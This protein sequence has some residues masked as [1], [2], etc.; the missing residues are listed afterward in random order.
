[1][2]PP[3][4]HRSRSRIRLIL[5]AA[6]LV[7]A[8]AAI[9]PLD[10]AAASTPAAPAPA[11]T[12]PASTTPFG[13]NLVKN[14]NAESGLSGWDASLS[15]NF[16]AQTYGKPGRGYPSKATATAIGGGTH[17]FTPGAYDNGMGQCDG[18]DQNFT[19]KG[20]GSLIDTGHVK[21]TLKGYAGTNGA[22]DISANLVLNFYDSQHHPVVNSPA[23]I[24]KAASSTNET[25]KLLKGS[26]VLKK[27]TRQFELILNVTGSSTGP[28]NCQGFWDN[29]SV[30]LTKV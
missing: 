25:Y 20:I 15:P 6:S 7:L 4:L 19:L 28:A 8:V 10:M 3:S 24:A 17:F 16:S 11:V 18:T 9:A 30:T 22:A 5:G 26:F 14:G 12:T 1:M 27:T 13:V 23:G 29:I 21:V 2:Q